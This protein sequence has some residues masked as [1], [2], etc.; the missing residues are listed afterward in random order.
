MQ[1]L[2]FRHSV[3]DR[4]PNY[5]VGSND[6][7]TLLRQGVTEAMYERKLRAYGFRSP[8]FE[9]K[10][11]VSVE[12]IPR[13]NAGRRHANGMALEP[14]VNRLSLEIS[15]HTLSTPKGVIS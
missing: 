13:G 1:I 7:D 2:P 3:H 10:T 5:D 12:V 6:R 11:D 8:E 9:I 4:F 15:W 14:S